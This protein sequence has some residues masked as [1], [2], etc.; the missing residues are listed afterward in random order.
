MKPLNRAVANI[1]SKV[2]LRSI[3]IVPFVLQLFA[4]VTLVGYLSW[5]NGQQAVNDVAS[6]L[7]QEISDRIQQQLNRYLEAPRIINQINVNAI[8]LNQLNIEDTSS[9]TSQFW[10]QRFLFDTANVSAIYFGSATGEFIGLG[11]Q[12]NNTWQISRVGKVTKGKFHSFA[13]DNRGKPTT[14][15]EIGK[16]YDPRIRPWYQKAV[17]ANKPV[18]SDI[19]IDFKEPRLKI[20]FAQPLYETNGNLRGVIGVDFVLSHIGEFLDLLKIGESGETFIMER[21]GLIIV[22]STDEEPFLV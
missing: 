21:S 19:Y 17:Q 11:F 6:Q 22:S 10:Q 12:N 20:T 8:A 15:L 16:D 2:S 9:L 18:W 1:Y 13:T 4:A 7:R 14:L 5:R 3:L